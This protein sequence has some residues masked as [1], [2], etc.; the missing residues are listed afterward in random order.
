MVCRGF[1]WWRIGWL[2]LF[3]VFCLFCF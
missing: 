2:M 3:R 1:G